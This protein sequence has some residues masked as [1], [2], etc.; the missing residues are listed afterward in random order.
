ML[1]FSSQSPPFS[2]SITSTDLST[3]TRLAHLHITKMVLKLHGMTTASCTQR[4]AVVLKEKNVPFELVPVD[5]SAGEQK[6]PEYM[7]K[8]PYVKSHSL[9]IVGC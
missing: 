5:L 3:T 9:S 6:T 4:V 2:E 8:Q 7:E 1:L